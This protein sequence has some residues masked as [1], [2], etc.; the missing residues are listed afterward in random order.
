MIMRK[1]IIILAVL[2]LLG[3]YSSVKGFTFKHRNSAH[4]AHAPK[5]SFDDYWKPIPYIDSVT[6]YS[7]DEGEF[8]GCSDKRLSIGE[9]ALNGV[10]DGAIILVWHPKFGYFLTIKNDHIRKNHTNRVDIYVHADDMDKI[11]QIGGCKAWIFVPSMDPNNRVSV[12]LQGNEF[13]VLGE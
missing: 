2:S 11:T 10:P 13:I 1:F 3:A 12:M 5:K 7:Y 9:C 4:T 6:G 8:V